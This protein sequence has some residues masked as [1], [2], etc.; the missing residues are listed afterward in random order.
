MSLCNIQV[1]PEAAVIVVDTRSQEVTTGTYYAAA[2]IVPIA[3]WPAVVTGRGCNQLMHH[4][5]GWALSCP[6][7]DWMRVRLADTL[8]TLAQPLWDAGMPR[9]N[10]EIAVAGWSAELGRFIA[11]YHAYSSKDDAWQGPNRT[12]AFY[13]PHSDVPP[14]FHA[15]S[16]SELLDLARLQATKELERDPKAVIGG[17]YVACVLQR[18]EILIRTMD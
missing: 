6:D 12:Q 16:V 5:A 2:K 14:G 10:Y 11:E 7:F 8:P 3:H 13:A 4:T 9:M 17:R 1:S 18:D 15:R